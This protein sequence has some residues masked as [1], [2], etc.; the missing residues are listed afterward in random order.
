M[1]DS[2]L[3]ASL[4]ERT[5]SY[6]RACQSLLANG[7]DPER[8]RSALR[9]LAT[10]SYFDVN[11]RLRLAASRSVIGHRALMGQGLMERGEAA[12]T[13]LPFSNGSWEGAQ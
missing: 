2:S 4:E 13:E 7:V 1:S 5:R 11:R 6:W 8:R 10:L 9:V 12:V 3:S